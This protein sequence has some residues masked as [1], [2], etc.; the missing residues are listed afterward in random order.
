MKTQQPWH[1]AI[2]FKLGA[3]TLLLAAFTGLAF[4][5]W[6]ENG[7]GIFLALV[8]SGLSWCF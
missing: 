2:W 8:E 6:L 3:A 7:A 1:T 5:M 4:A